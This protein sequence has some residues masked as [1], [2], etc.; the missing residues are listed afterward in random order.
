MIILYFEKK[1]LLSRKK[2]IKLIRIFYIQ[3]E[4]ERPLKGVNKQGWSCP[5]YSCLQS[6]LLEEIE[7]GL[8]P[9]VNIIW[10]NKWTHFKLKNIFIN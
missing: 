8:C 10:Q 1:D 6:F 2:S 5:G 4:P 3:Y 7:E 9:E